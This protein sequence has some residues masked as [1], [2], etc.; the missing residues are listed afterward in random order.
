MLIAHNRLR[1]QVDKALSHEAIGLGANLGPERNQA[2]IT[3]F[4]WAARGPRG[5]RPEPDRALPRG[6]ARPSPAMPVACC[7]GSGPLRAGLG[8]S[9]ATVPAADHDDT[10]HRAGSANA[11]MPPAP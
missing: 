2:A 1:R 6:R 4:I 5:P 9:G 10:A 11:I 7:S 8:T 3:T